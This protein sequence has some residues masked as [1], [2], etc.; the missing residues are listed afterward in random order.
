M[1]LAKNGMKI[2]SNKNCIHGGKPQPVSNFDLNK[3][4]KDG[5]HSNCKDCR[6]AY[7]LN[8][9]T[10]IA[11]ADKKYR[12]THKE[13]IKEYFNTY[14]QTYY[15][16]PAKYD[17][18]ASKLEKYEEIRR[19]P[20]N[21]EFLQVKCKYDH[22]WFTPSNSMVRNRVY[23]VNG[24]VSGESNFYCSEECKKKCPVF[25]L[26]IDPY[27]TKCDQSNIRENILQEE[28]RDMVL[29]LDDH[30]CQM[31][32]RSTNEFPDLK[33]VCHHIIP[34]KIDPSLASDINNCTTVCTECHQKLHKIPECTFGFLGKQ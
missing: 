5:Y 25:N 21:S 4:K 14:F 30:T 1:S 3:D 34:V 11:K 18:Y 15:N 13:H 33:L 31:C 27:E 8:N 23:A 6:K 9:K 10:K 32:G 16:L 28:L 22:K 29:E 2:C 26:R 17:S 24:K 12:E 20:K 19:D 7:R